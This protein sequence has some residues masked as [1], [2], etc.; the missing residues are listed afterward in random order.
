MMI[1]WKNAYSSKDILFLCNYLEMF[2]VDLSVH[3]IS[4]QLIF[5]HVAL[6]T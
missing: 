1:L 3:Y 4:L 2:T 5:L 6:F